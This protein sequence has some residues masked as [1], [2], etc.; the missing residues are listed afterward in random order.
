MD[1]LRNRSAMALAGAMVMAVS[2]SLGVGEVRSQDLTST[3]P[4]QVLESSLS[5]E[6]GEP[7]LVLATTPS[8]WDR[9][10]MILEKRGKLVVTPGRP[11]PAVDW[12]S[13]AV[14]L[15]A[16]GSFPNEQFDV[17]VSDVRSRG[18]ELIL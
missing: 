18:S 15:V 3:V 17:N 7:T 4:H 16:L 14:I 5:G 2:L 8:E 10:M 9:A 1:T 11:A 13:Q 6:F 12:T